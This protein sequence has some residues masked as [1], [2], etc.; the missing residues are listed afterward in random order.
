[1]SPTHC[2]KKGKHYRYY[3][4]S[5]LLKGGCETCSVGSIPAGELEEVVVNQLRRVFVHPEMI[6]RTW[7]AVN[8]QD[9]SVTEQEVK[10]ALND[11][12]P[13][14]NE[15]FPAEQSRIVNLLIENVTVD[16]D[17]VD[18]KMRANGLE[19]LARDVS[20]YQKRLENA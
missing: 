14:W 2:L 5:Q 8:A 6:V 10:K 18:I 13:V 3:K 11:I 4:P 16:A 15:L 7:T 12:G 9:S 20:S 19:S 1:M 17:G